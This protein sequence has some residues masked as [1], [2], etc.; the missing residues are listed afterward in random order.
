MA[1]Q[2]ATCRGAAQ[3]PETRGTAGIMARLLA[4]RF[5][6]QALRMAGIMS[7]FSARLEPGKLSVPGGQ[8]GAPAPELAA[9]RNELTASIMNL[10]FMAPSLGLPPPV[11]ARVPIGFLR[12]LSQKLKLPSGVRFFTFCS[13]YAPILNQR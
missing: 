1:W 9:T 13:S 2:K 8:V 12:L 4:R 5:V 10:R 7:R 3:R 11:L 6:D